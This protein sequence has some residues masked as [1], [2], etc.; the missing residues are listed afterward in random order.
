MDPAERGDAAEEERKAKIA[1]AKERECARMRAEQKK[2]NDGLEALD[3]LQRDVP[4]EEGPRGAEQGASGSTDRKAADRMQ[5]ARAVQALAAARRRKLIVKDQRETF[6]RNYKTQAEQMRIFQENE[7][8]KHRARVKNR[9]D[10][11]EQIKEKEARRKEEQQAYIRAGHE[12]VAKREAELQR[13]EAIKQEKV[14]APLEG[15]A[16][17]VHAR[18][19]RL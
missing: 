3:A 1:A 7:E 11:L 19:H 15:R 9:D 16:R 10:I 6:E 2:M 13:L 17:Q 5:D 8:R 18:R 14:A 4:R 12:A